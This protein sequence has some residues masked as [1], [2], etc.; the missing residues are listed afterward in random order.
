M[1]SE[2]CAFTADTYPPS[3]FTLRACFA[4]PPGKG[5]KDAKFGALPGGAKLQISLAS[6]HYQGLGGLKNLT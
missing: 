4:I 6:P 3:P 1:D 2:V 5:A